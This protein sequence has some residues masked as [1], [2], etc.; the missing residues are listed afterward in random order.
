MERPVIVVPMGDPAGVGPEIVIKT[1]ADPSLPAKARCI[2]VGDVRVFQRA[3]AFP[4]MPRPELHIISNPKEGLYRPGVLNLIN[5]PCISPKDYTIGKIS[6]ACG[7]AAYNCIAKAVMLAM[8]GQADA[9]STPPIN[10]EA[11]RAAGLPYIGHT[12]IFGALTHT[13][14]PLTIFE[15]H[16]LRIFFLTRHMS[17]RQACDAITKERIIDYVKRSHAILRQLGVED[18]C[19]AIAGL[20]PHCGEHGLFGNEESLA[21]IPAVMALQKLGYSVVGPIGSDSVFHQALNGKYS[22]VL[23]LYHDQGHIAAKTLDFYR[24]IS[25][26]CGMP[27]LRTSVDHGTAFDVAGQGIASSTSMQEAILVAVKYAHSI[28]RGS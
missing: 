7:Q 23:S 12:E 14:D 8:S 11:L 9:V 5:L 10:K 1:L 19:M 2:A 25:I 21:I 4:S 6:A 20:N 22:S 17:L 24:T 15:V 16:G 18:G 28:H 13:D 3:L 27:I 26:T